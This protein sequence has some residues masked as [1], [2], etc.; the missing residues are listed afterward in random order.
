MKGNGNWSIYFPL[1]N[2]LKREYHV[3]IIGT[4]IPLVYNNVHVVYVV[5]VISNHLGTQLVLL[6]WWFY[7]VYSFQVK[8]S[9]FK[10]CIGLAQSDIYATLC[11]QDDVSITTGLDCRNFIL[12][13]PDATTDLYRYT[14]LYGW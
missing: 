12:C 13:S 9:V 14:Q 3:C 7:V 10:M 4:H 1:F 5:I 11:I 8:H 2:L 6:C